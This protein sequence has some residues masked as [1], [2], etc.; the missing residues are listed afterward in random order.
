MYAKL[1]Q[2]MR[3]AGVAVSEGPE[4]AGTDLQKVRDFLFFQGINIGE[5]F[6]RY[7]EVTG[8]APELTEEQ[9]AAQEEAARLAA[10][11]A[12]QEEAARQ[13]AEAERVATEEA[14]RQAAEA[15][16]EEQVAD[17]AEEGGE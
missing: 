13:A 2:D 7:E 15:E 10:E 5:D 3:N 1:K 8:G 11:Q 17:E 4:L 12:A 16:A 6:H 14:A 9:I